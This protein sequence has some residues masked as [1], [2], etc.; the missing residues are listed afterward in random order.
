MLLENEASGNHL[1]DRYGRRSGLADLK[2]PN[3]PG[4][5][6]QQHFC[7]TRAHNLHVI[8][9]AFEDNRVRG[10]FWTART[11]GLDVSGTRFPCGISALCPQCC[12]SLNLKR[13]LRKCLNVEAD[14]LTLLTELCLVCGPVC[15]PQDSRINRDKICLFSHQRLNT[16]ANMQMCNDESLKAKI[17]KHLSSRAPTAPT[18]SLQHSSLN[19]IGYH[20]QLQTLRR[21]EFVFTAP[22]GVKW[23]NYRSVSWPV[24]RTAASP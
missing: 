12:S 3:A 18:C 22:F 21:R 17:H 2:S 23:C 7:S 1:H 6:G 10:W 24:S 9:Q 5:G 14:Q 13:S 16:V 11:L 20:V 19:L 4:N 8:I 15:L